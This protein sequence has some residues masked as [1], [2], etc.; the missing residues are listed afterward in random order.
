[1]VILGPFLGLLLVLALF[2]GADYA[3]SCSL[4]KRPTFASAATLQKV[5]RDAS[6]VGVA[7]LGMTMIIIAGGIDL[8][9]G[10]AMS[11]CATIIAWCFRENYSPAVGVSA[12]ILA[13]CL[14]GLINGALMMG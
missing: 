11:F 2:S 12:G 6:Q 7:A 8:S 3:R 10:A 9:A 4:G 13:G 14:A 1:M 5:L